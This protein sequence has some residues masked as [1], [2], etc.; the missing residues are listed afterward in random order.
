MTLS[1]RESEQS[2]ELSSIDEAL[3]LVMSWVLRA[4]SSS[5]PSAKVAI[6]GTDIHLDVI[7]D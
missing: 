6:G 1:S 5:V 2:V 3:R 4:E 7:A